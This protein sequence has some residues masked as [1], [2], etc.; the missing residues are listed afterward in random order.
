MILLLFL[1]I[2]FFLNNPAPP[3]IYPLPLH[4]PLPIPSGH[5]GGAERLRR[6]RAHRRRERVRDL[7]ARDPARREAGHRHPRHREVHVD[8]ER[9]VLAARRREL[10]DDES[11]DARA[12]QLR[13][14]VLHRVQSRDGRR[15]RERAADPRRLPRLPEVDRARRGHE[16]VEGLSGRPCAGAARPLVCRCDGGPTDGGHGGVRPGRR[17]LRRDGPRR[18]PPA[19]PRRHRDRD[20]ARAALPGPRGARRIGEPG[21]ARLP[22]ADPRGRCREGHDPH[23]GPAAV[24]RD[25]HLPRRAAGELRPHRR[26]SVRG[27]ARREVAPARQPRRTP[28]GVP[29][30]PRRRPLRPAAGRADAPA[31]RV[32][33][34]ATDPRGHVPARAVPGAVRSGGRRGIRLGD[35]RVGA[36]AHRARAPGV[37]L[38]PPV[39]P[40][41][42]RQ[43]VTVT[44][45]RQAALAFIFVTVLLDMLA[46]GLIAPVLAPLVVSFYGGDTARA[47]EIYGVAFTLF[48]A[49]QFVASPVLGA[50]SDR[51]GRRPIVLLPNL[52]LGLDYVLIALA[53][54]VGWLLVGRVLSGVTSASITAAGAYVADVTPEE[55]RAAG[56]GMIG[57]AFGLGFVLGPA[58]GGL[59]GSLGPRVPLWVAAALSLVHAAYG[60]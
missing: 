41:R 21:H 30:G 60:L 29:A 39:P 57:A 49:M 46:L 23:D 45:R 1:L 54:N 33:A 38:R 9:A 42:R 47:A 34:L 8:V 27:R 3:E 20:A 36:A 48:A 51:F 35:L 11:G 4:A 2:F 55:R 12:G 25:V 26:R 52:G 14:H 5:R 40:S 15:R 7:L 13:Q 16:R 31:A 22:G 17:R 53:P 58:P 10:A 24:R 43:R 32:S 37:D 44:A 59:L 50:L 18:R 6:R 19:T 56:V 28:H